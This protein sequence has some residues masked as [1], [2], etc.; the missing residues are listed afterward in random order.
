MIYKREKADGSILVSGEITCYRDFRS[1]VCG[2]AKNRDAQSILCEFGRNNKD[3][4]EEYMPML[5]KDYALQEQ[6]K[7]AAAWE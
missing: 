6:K 4:W 1:C 3:K 7:R 5:E 2:C